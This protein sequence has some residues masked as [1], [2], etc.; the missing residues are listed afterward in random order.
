MHSSQMETERNDDYSIFTLE[1]RPTYDFQQEIL[2]NG[3]DME[4]LSPEWLR[5]EIAII[6]DNMSNNYKK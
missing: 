2:K 6:I 1:V 5:N 3:A 4:V